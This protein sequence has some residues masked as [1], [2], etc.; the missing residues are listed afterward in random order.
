MSKFG[1]CLSNLSLRAMARHREATEDLVPSVATFAPAIMVVNLTRCSMEEAWQDN[2]MRLALSRRQFH[3]RLGLTE[4]EIAADT[5]ITPVDK[6]ALLKCGYHVIVQPLVDLQETSLGRRQLSAAEAS[7][8]EALRVWT[9]ALLPAIAMQIQGTSRSALITDQ[10]YDWL[11]EQ[12][13]NLVRLAGKSAAGKDIPQMEPGS[14][15]AAWAGD[16][17]SF[18]SALSDAGRKLSLKFPEEDAPRKGEDLRAKVNAITQGMS[19]GQ[20]KDRNMKHLLT[21]R[22]TTLDVLAKAKRIATKA[23]QSLIKES[24][25][26]EKGYERLDGLGPYHVLRNPDAFG[27]RSAGAAKKVIQAQ[28]PPSYVQQTSDVDNRLSE[29]ELAWI[30]LLCDVDPFL[31]TAQ[32]ILLHDEMIGMREW[33]NALRGEKVTPCFLLHLEALRRN[34]DAV[35]APGQRMVVEVYELLPKYL[36]LEARG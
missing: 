23:V 27:K 14:E 4:E 32:H 33:G 26:S 8:T 18:L 16:L 7:I 15:A 1:N 10:T 28:S 2:G 34:P 22:I 9:Y 21:M 13:Q 35:E 3:D 5:V 12:A 20:H 29:S 36:M 30:A 6:A 24:S 25:N 11:S 17:P 31:I 19:V